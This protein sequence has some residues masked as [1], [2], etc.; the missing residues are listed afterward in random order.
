LKY[1]IFKVQLH[2]NAIYHLS[3]HPVKGA[4]NTPQTL[5]P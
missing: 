4:S 1:K 2:L 5:S 3:D